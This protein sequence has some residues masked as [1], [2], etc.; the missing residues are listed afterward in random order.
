MK[1]PAG[2]KSTRLWENKSD[3]RLSVHLPTQSGK[4]ILKG[5]TS[6]EPDYG[7][8]S[9]FHS[10]DMFYQYPVFQGTFWIWC[11]LHGL[12]IT[13]NWIN[14]SIQYKCFHPLVRQF[15]EYVSNQT[16]RAVN[17][18]LIQSKHTVT[19]LMKLQFY[20]R[21]TNKTSLLNLLTQWYSNAESNN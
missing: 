21:E 20:K 2:T 6:G 3:W 1:E 5:K 18:T 14:L 4:K 11:F 8:Y 13:I 17:C 19:P 10:S 12:L 7:L 9:V 16:L 15:Q